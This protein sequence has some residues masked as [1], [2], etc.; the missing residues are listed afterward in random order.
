MAEKVWGL[1]QRRTAG[2]SAEPDPLLQGNVV[3]MAVEA[4]VMEHGFAVD[5]EQVHEALR[6]ACSHLRIEA[7]LGSRE[8]EEL[9][10]GS[11]VETVRRCLDALGSN[12]WKP[13]ATEEDLNGTLGALEIR[14]RPDLLLE[15]ADG[16]LVVL[17]LKT[18]RL[19]APKETREGRGFQLP[20]YHALVT[21]NNPGREIAGVFYAS[22]SDREPGRLEGFAGGEMQTLMPGIARHAEGLAALIGEGVFPPLA[23][24]SARC[25]DCSFRHLCR[26]SPEERLARKAQA[27]PRLAVLL[28]RDR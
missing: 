6:R 13:L 12:G 15:D 4:L 17:D 20:F 16:K 19:P 9:F 10:L 22:V 5:R 27:D 2:V 7:A 26:K 25:D 24:K 8:L 23:S 21:Q 1:R 14:G 3:H 18:G 11:R 28:E